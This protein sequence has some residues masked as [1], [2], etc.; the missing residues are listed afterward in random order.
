[1][2]QMISEMDVARVRA[3]TGVKTYVLTDASDT[4]KIQNEIEKKDWLTMLATP[5]D[6]KYEFVK[7]GKIRTHEIISFEYMGKHSVKMV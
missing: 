3:R 1:M 7:D 4:R 6:K 2:E 5:A